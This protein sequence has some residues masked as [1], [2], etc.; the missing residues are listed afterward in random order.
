MA[1]LNNERIKENKRKKRKGLIIISVIEVLCAVWLTNIIVQL[2][3]VVFNLDKMKGLNLNYS[4]ITAII[5]MVTEPINRYIFLLL[6]IIYVAFLVSIQ[7][8][9]SS[10]I[11][12]IDTF[13]V[14]PDIEKPV[15]SGNGQHGRERF[16]RK[17]EI[18]QIYDVFI[19]DGDISKINLPMGGI[20]VGM[21][22]EGNKEI[23][24]YIK[25][26]IRTLLASGT[27][28]GKTRRVMLVTIGLQILSGL[29]VVAS[30]IKG[31]L[32]YYTSKFAKKMGYKVLDF[33]L[34]HDG[35]GV[36]WNYMQPILDELEKGKVSKA[37]DY[38]WD[39]VSVLVGEPKGEPIWHNGE[40]ATIAA[41]I[42]IIA[43]D[44][45]KEYRNLTNVY[46]FLAMM[47]QPDKYGDM[48]FNSYID[49]LD[50]SHPAKGIS[51]VATIAPDRTRGS[52]FTSALGT[53]RLFTSP[54]IAEKTSKSDFRLEDIGKEKSIFYMMVP[55][56]QKAYYPLVSM[57]INQMYT[58]LVA[59][60]RNNGGELSIPTDLDLDEVGNFPFIPVLGS[61][62]SA[63]RS[64]GIRAN[65]IIQN[66]QQFE[67]KYKDDYET[68]MSNC[69]HQM[70]LLSNDDKTKKRWSNNLGS[71]TAEANS[72]SSS[73]SG[74]QNGTDSS[75]SVSSSSNLMEV[76]L[77]SEAEL[78]RFK[79]PYSLSKITGEY[80]AVNQLPDLSNYYFNDLYGLGD[81]EHNKKVIKQREAE[82]EKRTIPPLKLWGIWNQYKQSDS[83]VGEISGEGKPQR[84]S[85]L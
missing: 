66:E 19:W 63:G 51:L 32:F 50:D 46:Y 38:T 36:H 22:K 41:C 21:R 82:R 56:E 74:K 6:E 10:D 34:I 75:V 62:A 16:L 65:F 37:I 45:P 14:T 31:E 25:E 69:L 52:F 85:F 15:P 53:L 72:V 27:G 18:E 83:E 2:L 9:Y 79:A 40:T 20:V 70:Y 29:S 12:K 81:V 44:A 80:A 67:A 78:G 4:Y 30:D 43:I 39:L 57:L 5:N 54:N 77:L 35:E 68:I 48:P 76:K 61:I 28:T 42:L 17:D 84:I 26:N 49:K 11:K 64:R 59:E 55:D 71:Y 73:V 60:A 33:D 47:C 1:T 13:Y 8:P 7:N 3:E 58:A 23:I 24:Y